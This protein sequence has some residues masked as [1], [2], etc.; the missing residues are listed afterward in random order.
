MRGKFY[1]EAGLRFGRPLFRLS[2]HIEDMRPRKLL[3]VK[4]PPQKTG[5]TRIATESDA[6]DHFYFSPELWDQGMCTC[7]ES[8]PGHWDVEF[9][10]R[11]MFGSYVLV[12]PRPGYALLFQEGNEPAGVRFALSA[13]GIVI[14]NEDPAQVALIRPRGRQYWTLPKGTVET[15]ESREHA[16][17]REVGEETG[18]QSEIVCPLEPIEYW[19]WSNEGDQRVRVHKAVAY[20][21]MTAGEIGEPTA[22]AEIEEVG[23]FGMD[24]APS[25]LSHESERDVLVQGLE[26]WKKGVISS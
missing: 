19:F 8:Q 17:V 18:V 7:T 15:D 13:G 21:L 26:A 3:M 22:T 16:A 10:G 4:E 2:L 9:G 6:D 25:K 1:I 12:E 20:F 24:E 23:W 14:R 11:R 5:T